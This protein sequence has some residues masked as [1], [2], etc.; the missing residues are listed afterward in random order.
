MA[1]TANQGNTRTRSNT[2]AQAGYREGVAA[3]KEVTLQQGFNT[4]RRLF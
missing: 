1:R 4:G 2:P 3:G